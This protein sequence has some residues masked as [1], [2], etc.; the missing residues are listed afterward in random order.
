MIKDS[1]EVFL[2][3][4]GAS[5]RKHDKVVHEALAAHLDSLALKG[6]VSV[7]S[8]GWSFYTLVF[9]NA[10]RRDTAIGKIKN[11]QSPSRGPR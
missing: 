8:S 6:K 2:F 11:G 9:E 10:K 7:Q 5:L 4:C 3:A 1:K